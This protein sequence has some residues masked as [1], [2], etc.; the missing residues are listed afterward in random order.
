MATNIS[1]PRG[2]QDVLPE[3]WRLRHRAVGSFRRIIESA[4]Y[5]RI[6][7][8]TF[9]HTEVFARGVGEGTDIVGKEMYT[10]T[11]R[12]D[13]SLTLRPEG[14][15]AVARAF[16]E[17]GM[18]RLPLP[19]KLYYFAP[20]FRYEK[21]QEG[22]YREHW[23]LGAEALGGEHPAVDAE[24]ISLLARFYDELGVPGVTLKL[25]SIGD[26]TTRPAYRGKLVEYLTPYLDELDDDSRH[27]LSANPLRIFDSKNERVCEIMVDAPQDCRPPVSRESR[28]LRPG[29]GVARRCGR[30]VHAR[31]LARA[32]P[33]LLHAHHL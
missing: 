1:A 30:G 6:M 25:N 32:R 33:R 14:T 13:R 5:G 11:D 3:D 18:H 10:F 19:V 23:Q 20:M 31:R 9:E 8:P 29:E 7:T 15:A 4:G 21:P 12:S 26:E 27:R 16:V 28:A 24:L 2:T 17:H 22:R